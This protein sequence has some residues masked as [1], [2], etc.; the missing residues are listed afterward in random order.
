[1]DYQRN[2]QSSHGHYTTE[3]KMRIKQVKQGE[4][5]QGFTF[6]TMAEELNSSA[7]LYTLPTEKNNGSARV[8]FPSSSDI[9]P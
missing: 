3:F 2:L 8:L 5:C 1:M 4:R 7:S 6:S 9:V